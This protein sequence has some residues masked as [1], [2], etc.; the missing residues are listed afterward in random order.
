M[1]LIKAAATVSGL[2]LLSRITGLIRENI[3]AVLYGAGAMTDAFFV[4]FRLPNLLRRMFAEGAFSQAFVPLLGQAKHRAEQADNRDGGRLAIESMVDHTGTALFWVLILISALGVAA[5]PILV[6]LMASGLSRDPS[7]YEASILMTRWMFPY[8]F[9][10]GMVALSAG[11]LNTWK[12]VAVPAF[13]PVLLNLSFIGSA[14]LLRDWFSSPIYALAA[15]VVIGG[16]LQMAIQIPALLQLKLLPRISFN[17]RAAFADPDTRKIIKQ[18]LPAMLAVSVSQLSLVLNTQIASRLAA[19]SVSWITFGDR[20]M[21]FPTAMLGVALGTVLL[22]S[23]SRAAATKDSVQYSQLLDWGLRLVFLLAIPA[24]IGLALMAEP[25]TAMLFHYG[26]FT[27]NDVQ[28]TRLAVLGYSVGLL[29]LIA[30]KVLAP[31]F[32]ARQ[33]VKTP[34]MIGIA[35]L[36]VTQLMNFIFVPTLKHAGLTLSISIGALINALWLYIG[37]RKAK[38][39][40]PTAGWLKYLAKLILAGGLMA[41]FVFFAS[42]QFQWV[43]MNTQPVLRIVAA[44]GIIAIAG[45]IYAATLTAM[46]IRPRQFMR[47]ST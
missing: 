47:K 26:K 14:L 9:F 2:T 16:V 32:F 22:P 12:K 23:L 11:I 8:I 6:Y 33:D 25:L 17:L 28:M 46:G 15:G 41:G 39:Y 13:T 1:N 40:A 18:M 34:L 3:T 24:T 35:V 10:M 44:L 20:L 30:I 21:E 45:A 42:A 31:A 19:G 38:V 43:A 27:A 5:S 4:A 7:A 29:G 37:L 36:I